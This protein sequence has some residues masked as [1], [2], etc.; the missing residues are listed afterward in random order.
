M[1]FYYHQK[2]KLFPYLNYFTIFSLGFSL[3]PQCFFFVFCFFN[4]SIVDLQCC[5]SFRCIAKWY[6]IFFIHSSVDE[7]LGCFHVLA[8]VKSAMNT[9]VHVSFQIIVFSRYMPS[10]G[11]SG[12]HGTSIL[13]FLR[14]LHTALH[15]GYTNLHYHQSL[16]RLI[17]KK[18]ERT[19][20]NKIRNEKEVTTNTTEI[21]RII[22]DYHSN[23][24]PIKWTT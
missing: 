24:M 13:S 4:W 19:Q 20:I 7:P 1:A 3:P 11:I 14:N 5:V 23:Y 12:S 6:H 21:Q 18:R 9:E 22:R 16:A 2:L 17:K 8:I 10:S 15:S